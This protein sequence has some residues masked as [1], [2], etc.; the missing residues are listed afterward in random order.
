MSEF[1]ILATAANLPPSVSEQFDTQ[2]GT[3]IPIN[4]VL[5]ID[6][7]DST[8]NDLDGIT[9]KGGVAAGDPPGTG[10]ANEVSIYLT[11]R[12][13]GTTTTS[14]GAGQNQNF[15]AFALGTTP[16]TYLFDTNIVA[17]NVTSALGATYKVSASYRTDGAVATIIITQTFTEKE[18]GAMQNVVV[19]V[20]SV[21]NNFSISV[22]G[23]AGQTINWLAVSTY[24]FVS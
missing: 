20:A 14:D 24:N 3:G 6:A 9:T 19:G 1:H 4:H 2:N 16:G 12:V 10:L 17:Y 18:E 21:G 7:F 11:N 8:E 13:S 5:I 23:I 22:T 15:S